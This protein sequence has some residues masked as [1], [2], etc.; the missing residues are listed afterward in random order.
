[1]ILIGI[2]VPLVHAAEALTKSIAFRSP[3][4]S[5]DSLWLATKAQPLRLMPSLLVILMRP[6]LW[7]F[8]E[9][10]VS[11]SPAQSHHRHF[12]P[13]RRIEDLLASQKTPRGRHTEV[14]AWGSLKN[15]QKVTAPYSHTLSR[16]RLALHLT[17][18]VLNL[19][20]WS[21]NSLV[22]LENFSKISV[23]SHKLQRL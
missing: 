12:T 6:S 14:Q 13:G 8:P 22:G 10:G 18:L 5:Q 15:Q 2:K 11:S 21:M 16:A 9:G 7:S 20:I 23:A 17:K 3:S 19:R 1:M 4:L